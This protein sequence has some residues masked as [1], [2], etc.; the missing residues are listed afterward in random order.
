MLRNPSV[1]NQHASWPA[2][3]TEARPWVRSDAV[4]TSRRALL[5]SRGDYQAAVL[6]LI[7]HQ[8]VALPQEVLAAADDAS[9]ELTRFD[10]EV[11]VFTAPFASILLRTESASSS[12]VENLTSSAKQ[13][14]LAEL[15]AASSENA[16]L[17]VANVGAMNAALE[18]ADTIN[19]DAIIKMHE[20]LL[21]ESTPHYVGR[22]RDQ[23]V[24]IG[25]GAISPHSA[26]FIPPHHDRVPELM[27]DLTAFAART[28]LPVLVHAAIAHAQFETIHPFPDGNGRTGRA[29]LHSMLRHGGLTRNVTVPVSAGLLSDTNRYFEALGDYRA[30]ELAP[31][32]EA[33]VDAV[34][35]AVHNGRQL[36]TELRDVS[37]RWSST[38]P[39][40]AGS[41]AS[42]L[43]DV[44]LRHPV[45]NSKL[46]M[47]ELGVTEATALV[48]INTL[49]EHGVLAQTNNFK[50]NRIWHAP[51]V[52]DALDAFGAR[53]RR[54]RV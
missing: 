13:V 45:I 21:G 26:K 20:A 10:T 39:A 35:L 14:A 28:D 50:R 53:S 49:V 3:T 41:T 44:L 9:Q 25:G 38:V 48:A 29:L 31:I 1:P 40:R 54:Q 4:P 11:G 51:E 23:Q 33:L 27:R 2:I 15:Q 19:E 52:L 8:V 17:V 47:S 22:F 5:Q 34:F 7:E 12:E 32:V 42:R 18:L 37:D 30:G 24:W 46:V 16:K 6:P 36:V 43:W